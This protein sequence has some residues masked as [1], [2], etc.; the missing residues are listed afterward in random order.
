MASSNPVKKITQFSRQAQYLSERQ[1]PYYG[2]TFKATM[3]YVPLAMR[4]YRAVLYWQMER[5]F[6]GFNIEG[7]RSIRGELARENEAYVKKTAPKRYWDALIP[8][9]EIGC[10]RKVLDTDYLASLHKDNVELIHDDPVD[11]I[12]ETG[13]KTKSGR[14]VKADAIV[15]AIGFATQQMLFPMNITGRNGLSLN[16]YVSLP[17]LPSHS[18]LTEDLP[19]GTRL[20]NQWPRPTSG[21]AF[22]PSQTSSS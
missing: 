6:S 13:V 19:S 17:F 20:L 5:D 7:G 4:I 14:D 8:K 11:S 18:V 2:S 9:T 21:P 10:K 16:S 12:T 1:N 22:L 3:R 15:L